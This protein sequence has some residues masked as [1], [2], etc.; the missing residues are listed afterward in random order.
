MTTSYTDQFSGS[1]SAEADPL[2][3]SRGGTG[4][5]ALADHGVLLGSGT[6]P[7]SAAAAMTNGQILVGQ[8]GADPA[9]RTLTG[10]VALAAS[11]AATIANDAVSNAKLSNVATATLKGRATAGT[12][13]PEDL[14]PAE[15]AALLPTFVGDSGLGGTKGLVPAPAAGDATAGKFLMADGSW[16]AGRPMLT[17]NRIYYVRS[18]GSDSNSGLA[19]SAGEA[20]ASLARAVITV[21][22][23]DLGIYNV[24]IKIG[25]TGA[26]PEQMVVSAPCRRTRRSQGGAHRQATHVKERDRCRH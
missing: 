16:T 15:A 14:T 26:W 24:T 17:A 21:S 20:F 4:A 3:V 25:T 11:G 23:L 18:D 22:S 9:P 13:D 2:P 7:V 1:G 8:T 12:G 5:G 10:D 6:D 19:N